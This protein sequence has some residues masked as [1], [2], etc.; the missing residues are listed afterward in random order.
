MD[1]IYSDRVARLIGLVAH[2][3]YWTIFPHI[4]TL[5]LDNYHLKQLYVQIAQVQAELES[6][7]DHSWQFTNFI[8]PMIVL[9]IRIEM[10]NILRNSYPLFFNVSANETQ[11]MRFVNGVIT[12][13]LDPNIF[14]SRFS[15]LE[16]G[17]D[18]IDT[19]FKQ[20]KGKY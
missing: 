4:N 2:F 9:A 11:L 12:D 7:F 15:F 5:P 16:S 19:K 8:M 20:S 18:A 1:E 6:K 3:V 14:Y 10:E 17:K 13:V